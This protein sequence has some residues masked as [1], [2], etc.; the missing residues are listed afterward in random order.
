MREVRISLVGYGVVGH[1][2]V[3]V[4]SRKRKML[5]EL[6]LDLKLV[7][8]TDHTGTLVEED[9][10]SGEKVLGHRTLQE[11]ANSEM[12][13]KETIRS[14]NSEL[15]VEVTPTNIVHGQPGLGHMEEALASG[16]HV[17][18]SNK[19]P[20]VVAYNRLKRL[21][22]DN[23]VML[24]FEATVGGTMP[25]IN[26]IERTLVGN[27]IL[28]IRGIFNGTCNYILTR[29]ADEQYPFS[30]ALAEAQELGYAEADPTYDIEGVDTAAKI[31]ILA[32]AIFNMNVKYNDV[33]VRGI[34]EITPEALAL[35]KK[36]GYVIKLIGEVPALTV[37]PMLVP[38][39]SPLAVGSTLNA[40][41]IYTDLSGTITVTGLGAGGVE[42]AAAILSD[43]VSIYRTKRVDA[44]F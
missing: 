41:A 23:G 35:A 8:I 32:N 12:S 33:Q 9:G 26:L 24:K 13:A 16:K 20:L 14:V 27:T 15:V 28:G 18:T 37:R 30:R 29:M 31:V 10:I 7:S 2:V 39:R 19:G 17:V 25:L 21:A 3:D 40:A 36:H 22:D 5:R 6:G 44:I 38:I 4:I 42:T 34:T 43:I 1:G 11:I